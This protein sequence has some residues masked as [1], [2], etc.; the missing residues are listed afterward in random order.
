MGSLIVMELELIIS[1][2]FTSIVIFI[3]LC[4]VP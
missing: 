3:V 2:S 4:P 1:I